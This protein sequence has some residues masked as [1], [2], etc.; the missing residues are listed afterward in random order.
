VLAHHGRNF[1]H[2]DRAARGSGPEHGLLQLADKRGQIVPDPLNQ[3]PGGLLA[4]REAACCGS[5]PEPSRKLSPGG[6]AH[7]DNCVGR[8]DPQEPVIGRQ[9]SAGQE[10]ETRRGTRRLRVLGERLAV[11]GR[12]R[13]AFPHYHESDGSKKG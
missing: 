10:E 4:E 9:E 12:E 6:R 1:F 7:G 13:L 11:F 2:A 5:P 3:E 8:R